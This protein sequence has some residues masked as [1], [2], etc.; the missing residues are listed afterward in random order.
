[1]H[2]KPS[3]DWTWKTSVLLLT[4]LVSF[5]GLDLIAKA[6]RPGDPKQENRELLWI[7][8]GALI[9]VALAIGGNGRQFIYFQ[10]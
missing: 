7:T 6:L 5:Y 8:S 2:S 10:F 9:A 4:V 3:G 1:M